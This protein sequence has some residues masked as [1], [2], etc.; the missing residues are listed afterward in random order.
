MPEGIQTE[1]MPVAVRAARFL[2]TLQVAFALVALA[3]MIGTVAA[4]PDVPTLLLLL[5][6]ATIT[7]LLGRLVSRW[8]S[9][10]GAVRWGAVALEVIAGGGY[11][12]TA[13]IDGGLGR[14]ALFAP[15]AA[16]P[17]AVVV[18]LLTPPA[19]RWFDRQPGPGHRSGRRNRSVSPGR[20]IP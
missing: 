17:L 9:R 6:N 19:A 14:L 1:R 5:Y 18:A 3:I 15:G 11:V 2:M 12:A 4:D 16:L 8:P 20:G 10:H 7:A 13:A